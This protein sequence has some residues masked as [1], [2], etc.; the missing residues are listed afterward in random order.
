MYT[1]VY[2]RIHFIC[3]LFGSNSLLAGVLRLY[4]CVY[5]LLSVSWVLLHFKSILRLYTEVYTLFICFFVLTS[6]LEV[7]FACA[8][9]CTSYYLFL[10]FYTLF[11]GALRLHT[12]HVHSICMLFRSNSVLA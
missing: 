4:T 5:F 11:T 8:H 9:T 10:E 6:F 7:F 1:L 12:P 2:Q 3:L